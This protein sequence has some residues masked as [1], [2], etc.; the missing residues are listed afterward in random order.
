VLVDRLHERRPQ[1]QILRGIAGDPQLAGDDEIRA[2]GRC[3]LV[4]RRDRAG[5]PGQVTDQ[6]VELRQNDSHQPTLLHTGNT[7]ATVRKAAPPTVPPYF[8]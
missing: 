1:H 7:E 6:R 2:G 3:L 4:R 5:V 8:E